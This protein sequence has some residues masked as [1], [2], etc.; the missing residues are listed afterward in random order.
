MN[1]KI[2]LTGISGFLGSNIAASLLTAGHEIIALKR[3]NSDLWRCASFVNELKLVDFEAKDWQEKISEYTP[4]III[5]TA[6]DGVTSIDRDNLKLQLQNI[7]LLS[8]LLEMAHRINVERFIGF[9]SQAEYGRLDTVVTEDHDLAP[10]TAYGIV[11]KIASEFVR[12]YCELNR[13][14]WYWLRIFSIYGENEAPN[15]MIPSTVKQLIST[16]IP[17]E[18]T[19]GVQRYAYLH[20]SDLTKCIKSITEIVPA[21]ESG[22]YNISASDALS[23]REIVT[24][25]KTYCK[26]DDAII[27]FGALQT[28]KEQS[29][30]VEGDM[31]KFFKK[32]CLLQFKNFEVGLKAT[33][34]SY[35][36][37]FQNNAY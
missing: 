30:L 26:K 36:N 35:V 25:I 16:E 1:K 22:I 29:M 10:V 11:K 23:L 13:I 9:G 28:R 19:L 32:I 2:L 37:R 12:T 31:T 21:P 24:M 18:F 17:L 20:I 15:W 14:H 4:Q 7:N 27:N 5:H 33:V 8:D 34:D 3:N 6:W